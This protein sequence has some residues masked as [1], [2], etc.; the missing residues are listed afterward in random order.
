MDLFL[1]KHPNDTEY[2]WSESQIQIY[3]AQ[4]LRKAKIVHAASMEGSNKGKVGGGRAKMQG[5]VAGEPDLRIYFE[6][7]RLLFIELK[8]TKGV[9]SEAQKKRI[10]LLRGLGFCVKVIYAGTPLEGWEKVRDAIGEF[11]EL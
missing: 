5:Q 7:P 6:G 2:S 9:L 1:G 8:L 4:E 10:P 11:N 3:I